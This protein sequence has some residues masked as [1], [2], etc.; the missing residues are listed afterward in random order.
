MAVAVAAVVLVEVVL[1]AHYLAAACQSLPMVAVVAADVIKA[2][3]LMV[4]Q[5]VDI[6]VTQAEE[7][8]HKVLLAELAAQLLFTEISAPQ[9]HYALAAMVRL[10]VVALAEQ[11]LD[12]PAILQ[13][14]V[15]P[16]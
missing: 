14:P 8:L 2:M 15:A 10:V 1:I 16:D 13:A 6:L 5:L 11:V 9:L 4:A 3:V 12:L 7:A